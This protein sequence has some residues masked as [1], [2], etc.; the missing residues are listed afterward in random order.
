[1]TPTLTRPTD[2]DAVC[3]A[4][5]DLARDAL[6]EIEGPDRVG[7]HL[8]VVAE[9]DRMVSHR[10]ACLDRGYVG[11]HWAVT[12]VRASRAKVA[13]VAEVVL[14]PGEGALLA[15][16]WVP[17]DERLRPGD[18]GVGDL[19]P[20][21]EDDLRLA[22]GMGT[23]DVPEDVLDDPLS[24]PWWEVGLGRVRVLS[25]F[26]RDDAADRWYAGESGPSSPMAQAAPATCASC[27]FLVPLSGALRQMFGVCAHGMSPSDGRVVSLDHGC[28]AHSEAAVVPSQ[29]PVSVGMVDEVGFDVIAVHGIATGSIEESAP[30]EELGH[31]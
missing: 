23:D 25:G 11:W 4:A 16:A 26:G 5:V 31:S 29:V 21:P 22:Q 9:A 12:V 20:T 24:P 1:M 30:A 17:W 7:E 15:P 2:A 3:A 6:V 8:G 18:L 28:G 14:V 27:G 10:F 13:T 19:L